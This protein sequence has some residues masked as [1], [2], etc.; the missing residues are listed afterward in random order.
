MK[1]S[2]G[3]KVNKILFLAVIA[4]DQLG[5]FFIRANPALDIKIIQNSGLPFGLNLPGVFNLAAVVALLAWFIFFYFQYLETARTVNAFT[6]IVAGASSNIFDRLYFG[7]VTDFINLGI[8]TTNFADVA[9]IIG[10]ALLLV[11]ITNY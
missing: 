5:K 11:K 6:L 10:I 4:A 2:D 7:S 8:T 3:V 1:I 9:I